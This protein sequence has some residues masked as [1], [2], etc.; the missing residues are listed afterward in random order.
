MKK[1]LI[2]DKNERTL[3]V[4]AAFLREYSDMEVYTEMTPGNAFATYNRHTP[5]VVALDVD[6]DGFRVAADL[7]DRD[8]SPRVILMSNMDMPENHWRGVADAFYYSRTSM[9][10][11]LG[12]ARSL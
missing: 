9:N 12:I 8:P 1:I 11:L 6:T 3:N 2:V 10:N 4:A 5:E 7:R